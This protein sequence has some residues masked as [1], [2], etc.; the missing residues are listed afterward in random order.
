MV[1]HYI[2][3]IKKDIFKFKHIFFLSELIWMM[4][5]DDDKKVVQNINNDL[6]NFS[7]SLKIFLHMWQIVIL[8]QK[9]KIKSLAREL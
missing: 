3:K 1:I 7:N 9:L 4:Q 2:I 5:T 8:K 6:K